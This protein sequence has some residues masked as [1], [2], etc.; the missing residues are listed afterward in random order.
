MNSVDKIARKEAHRERRME[1]L[2]E[3]LAMRFWP[4][5]WAALI[6]FGTDP[7]TTEYGSDQGW[8][9]D[10]LPDGNKNRPKRQTWADNQNDDATFDIILD[11]LRGEGPPS[12][13]PPSE[14]IRIAQKYELTP[15]WLQAASNDPQCQ[16][17]LPKQILNLFTADAQAQAP[18]MPLHPAVAAHYSSIARNA[19]KASA[20]GAAMEEIRASIREA[21]RVHRGTF[22][23]RGGIKKLAG[24]LYKKHQLANGGQAIISEESIRNTIRQVRTETDSKC[25]QQHD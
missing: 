13:R 1:R 21:L 15:P 6:T 19:R 2:R 11:C 17:F 25:I 3:L 12:N 23:Q 10:W 5:R 4:A 7:E 22:S 16:A 9:F 20:K 24:E 14:W 8:G 18:S